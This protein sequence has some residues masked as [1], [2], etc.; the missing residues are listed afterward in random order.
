MTRDIRASMPTPAGAPLAQ[1]VAR[2]SS[3]TREKGRVLALE[4]SPSLLLRHHT[5]GLVPVALTNVTQESPFSEDIA[6]ASH[7][8][9]AREA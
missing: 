6:L 2:N 4:A 1:P 5:N 3:I 9:L 8:R 7:R